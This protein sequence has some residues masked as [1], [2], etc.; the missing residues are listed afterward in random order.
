MMA[1]SSLE[2][3]RPYTATR[4]GQSG[5]GSD[6]I[7]QLVDAISNRPVIIEGD[8]SKIFRVVQQENRTRTRATNYNI[9]AAGAR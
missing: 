1:N 4:S 9:L 7:Q 2:N 3:V 5:I 8:T 6:A